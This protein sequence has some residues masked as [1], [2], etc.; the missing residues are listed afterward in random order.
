[1][2]RQVCI[3]VAQ[4]LNVDNFL[5]TPPHI[6]A[7]QPTTPG[8]QKYNH[9]ILITLERIN[10]T[11]YI[12]SLTVYYPAICCA[13]LAA[14]SLCAQ[15][16]YVL[17]R[18][19]RSAHQTINIQLSKLRSRIFNQSSTIYCTNIYG[20]LQCDGFCHNDSTVAHAN[21][22]AVPIVDWYILLSRA[23]IQ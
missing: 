15:H 6:Y 11:V 17:C 7:T 9:T 12:A 5:N 16:I 18:A 8:I 21:H 13:Q 10:Y 3:H 1:M 23:H 4:Q 19:A 14:K 20:T 2:C 22:I